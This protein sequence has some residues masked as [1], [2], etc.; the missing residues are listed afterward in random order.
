MAGSPLRF[1]EVVLHR[2]RSER[3]AIA[4]Q[5][6]QRFKFSAF[7][8]EAHEVDVGRC[9]R[10]LENVVKG[11]SCQ[12]DGLCAGGRLL[13]HAEGLCHTPTMPAIANPMACPRAL[14][15]MSLNI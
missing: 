10:P 4:A 5:T 7:Y 6:A 14:K 2:D 11:N 15:T 13:V 8:V 3:V 9:L 12:D 1:L